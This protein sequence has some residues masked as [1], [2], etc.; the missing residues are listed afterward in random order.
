MKDLLIDRNSTIK[1]ALSQISK[2]G[3]RCLVVVDTLNKMM[4]SLSDGDIR[5][6]ILKGKKITSKISLIY[7]KKPRFFFE[8][9]VNEKKIKEM[10]LKEKLDLIPIVDQKRKVIKMFWFGGPG[11]SNQPGGGSRDLQGPWDPQGNPRN[12]RDPASQIYLK[13]LVS[14]FEIIL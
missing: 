4:G 7:R 14:Y 8:N 6:S 11:P 1:E 9:K 10:F 12:P 5:R 3:I 2:K 13:Y